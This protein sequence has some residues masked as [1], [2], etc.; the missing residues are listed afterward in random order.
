[1]SSVT[2]IDIAFTLRLSLFDC[3]RFKGLATHFDSI[4]SVL[5]VLSAET[6]TKFYYFYEMYFIRLIALLQIFT[7]ESFQRMLAPIHTIIPY[8]L[9]EVWRNFNPI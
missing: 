6:Q 5:I 7:S 1:M 3:I 2:P 9:S 4:P 8:P